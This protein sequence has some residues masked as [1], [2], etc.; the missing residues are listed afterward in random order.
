MILLRAL[1]ALGL[2][3][4]LYLLCLL[5][6]IADLGFVVLSVG[7]S[8]TLGRPLQGNTALLLMATIPTLWALY[9]VFVLRA[10]SGPEP[11]SLPVEPEQAPAL[12]A[13]VRELAAEIG[14]RPPAEIRLIA[15]V[16]AK[17][18]EETAFLGLAG[19][20][21]RLYIGL[22][23]LAGLSADEL[24]V[25]LCHELGHYAHAHTRLGAITYRGHLSLRETLDR[26]AM[27]QSPAV[28]AR[29]PRMTPMVSWVWWPFLGYAALYF[30]LSSA[31]NR[32][33]E[34]QADAAAARI[35]G[36]EVAAEALRRFL[37]V[38]PVA[39][40]AFTT[41]CLVP[42]RARGC[43]P[44][45]PL[46][47][48]A[49]MAAGPGRQSA[50]EERLKAEL[51]K[52]GASETRRAWKYDSHPSPARRLRA[53]AALGGPARV[54]ERDATPSAE[55]FPCHAP[56]SPDVRRCLMPN[57]PAD[58]VVLPW[59]E[60]LELTAETLAAEPARR[61]VR[62]ARQVG[63]PAR[64]A[65]ETV[66]DLLGSGAGG[67]LAVCL[68]GPSPAGEGGPGEVPEEDG[69]AGRRRLEAA[70]FALAGQALV[71]RGHARWEVSWSGPCRLVWTE[72]GARAAGDVTVERLREV[73]GAAAAGGLAEAER[74]RLYLGALGVDPGA[75]LSQDAEGARRRGASAET[76]TVS[77]A[78]DPATCEENRKRLV[79]GLV[80]VGFASVLFLLT[81]VPPPFARESRPIP[82]LRPGVVLPTTFR[83]ETWPDAGPSPTR[84]P[85]LDLP[86]LYRYEHR[87]D[88]WVGRLPL[89]AWKP[90][91]LKKLKRL[92][93]PG[94]FRHFPVRK[95][96]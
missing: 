75:W 41:R 43:V 17:V 96:R 13:A 47:V 89:P 64:P 88:P 73:V 2:L 92:P 9:G 55:R 14:T 1:L 91:R 8:I 37:G 71:T 93:T 21:R 77:A 72:R 6:V 40:G 60:W 46:A 83:E 84:L 66:L 86:G 62:A 28:G 5:L 61:L 45:D 44:D 24:R 94:R 81:I 26:V 53:L 68:S 70:L 58:T 90:P 69:S 85:G 50:L 31:V 20:T 65:L 51:E 38:L 67:R 35:V 30:R 15:E 22:P 11:G 4:G 23:L 12:W 76:M 49:A 52:D 63:G 87:H 74:L 95:R 36:T 79:I 59:R 16:N 19:G 25:V 82:G 7:T 54:G 48:F 34:L 10:P 56:A 39:W 33:Q 80:S 57:L 3:A 27:L 42:M 78:A 18:T 29:G 32:R